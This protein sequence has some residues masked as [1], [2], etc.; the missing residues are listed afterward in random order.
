MKKKDKPT[1]AEILESKLLEIANKYDIRVSKVFK[2]YDCVYLSQPYISNENIVKYVE[3][4]LR[5]RLGIKDV[6]E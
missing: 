6:E 4:A 3:I 2:L 5:N 1:Q